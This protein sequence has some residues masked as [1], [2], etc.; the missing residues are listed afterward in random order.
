MARAGEGISEFW[1][2]D[3]NMQSQRTC[4]KEQN[5]ESPK[6]D[7]FNDFARFSKFKWIIVFNIVS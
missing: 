7:I 4:L 5:R 2:T 6:S 3:C 1:L